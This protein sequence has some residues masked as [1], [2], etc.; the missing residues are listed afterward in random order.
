MAFVEC[1]YWVNGHRVGR[2]HGFAPAK[3][4]NNGTPVPFRGDLPL[5]TSETR[6]SAGLPLVFSRSL[7]YTLPVSSSR[8]HR[9]HRTATVECQN[10][11]RRTQKKEKN[12][13]PSERRGRRKN[14][15]TSLM[16]TARQKH[17]LLFPLYDVP[18]LQPTPQ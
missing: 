13:K 14:D 3:T 11:G 9:Y 4:Q 12:G 17:R 7:H 6:P 8:M 2:P 15:S 10:A 18:G 5:L 1:M 16:H